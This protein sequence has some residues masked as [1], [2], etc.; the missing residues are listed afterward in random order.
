LAPMKP[1]MQQICNNILGH[2]IQ[3]GFYLTLRVS[4]EGMYVL[5]CY[6]Y[7]QY[8]QLN[9]LILIQNSIFRQF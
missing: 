4:F 9:H 5:C 3:K 8:M 1:A 7:I 6:S 2:L